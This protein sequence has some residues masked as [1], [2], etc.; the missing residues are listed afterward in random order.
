M[1]KSGD[2][3][4]TRNR[5]SKPE[6][7]T[8]PKIGCFMDGIALWTKSGL[9]YGRDCFMDKKRN[10]LWTTIRMSKPENWTLAKIGCFMDGL[11][12]GQKVVMLFG[13]T[14]L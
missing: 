12:Y 5:M 1:E 6:N 7:W 14:F 13:R 9:L 8:L 4:W 2:A 11:L 10:A 3:L